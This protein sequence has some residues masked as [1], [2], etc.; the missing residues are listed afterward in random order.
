[1]A[2]KFVGRG[3]EILPQKKRMGD[4]W[5]P[6]QLGLHAQGIAACSPSRN[7]HRPQRRKPQGVPKNCPPF[8]T[9]TDPK[10]GSRLRFEPHPPAVINRRSPPFREGGRSNDNRD[11]ATGAGKAETRPHPP[12]GR[13]WCGG[14]KRGPPNGGERRWILGGTG[15]MVQRCGRGSPEHIVFGKC[16]EGVARER[17]APLSSRSIFREPPPHV[18]RGWLLLIVCFLRLEALSGG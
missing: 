13:Y 7:G 4:L 11:P 17:G 18:S 16:T 9:R 14:A 8:L 2:D 15:T 3:G 5:R 6:Q 1:M 10:G 12:C